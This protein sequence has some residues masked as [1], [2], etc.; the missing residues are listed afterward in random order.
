MNRSIYFL[1][2]NR[3]VPYWRL[4]S[5]SLFAM[6]IIAVALALLPILIKQLL[7]SLYIQTNPAL[8]QTALLAIITLFIVHGIGNSINIY[9]IN[10]VGSQLGVEL[11][12]DIFNKLLRL[13]ISSHQH[14][15]RNSEIDTLLSTVNQITYHIILQITILIQDVLT[16]IGLIICIFYLN[17]EFA[18]LLLL[19]SSL[20]ILLVWI[21]HDHL[22]ELKQKR[23]LAADNLIQHLTKSIQHYRQIRLDNGQTHEIQRLV[24]TAEPIY[25]SEIQ[26]ALIKAMLI[27]LGQIASSAIVIAVIY[28]IIQ[29][30]PN[31]LMN[32]GKIAALSAAALLI[33]SPIKRIISVPRQLEHDQKN[34]EALFLFLDHV[35]EQDTGTRSLEYVHGKI[36]FEQVQFYS[37][38][39]E[40]PIL[41][42]LNFTIEPGEII[43]FTGY[44]KEEKNALID[45]ILRLYQPTSGK[46]L[47]DDHILTDI[48]LNNLYANICIIPKDTILL[49]ER[50]AG[51]IAYGAMKYAKE[52]KITAAAHASQAMKFIREM[53]E[54]LQT[55]VSEDGDNTRINKEQCQRITIARAFLKNAPILILDELPATDQSNSKNLFS[56]LE[57]LMQNRTSLIFNQEVPPLKRIDRIF[58]LKDGHITQ[59]P[60][61]R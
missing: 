6:L 40:K 23:M 28:S 34:I 11:R 60:N 10:K 37:D 27:P 48:E 7:D 33:I 59:N 24:K 43:I 2:L 25:Y 21:S 52:A 46:I 3:L 44:I 32:L 8:L 50:I 39:Q 9:T 5:L 56:T 26:Q 14:T 13:P 51:N 36:V 16:I 17:Q 49:D 54:G 42:H 31:D 4:L 29:Q 15:D 55:W 1:L 19:I 41:N 20:F 38:P 18:L 58:V 45:L 30:A 61:A 53:S 47:L 22:K 12:R 57:K 35:Y